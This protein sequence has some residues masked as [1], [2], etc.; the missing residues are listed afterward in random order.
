MGLI[1]FLEAEWDGIEIH[2]IHVELFRIA[3]FGSMSDL[4]KITGCD[5]EYNCTLYWAR[6]QKCLKKKKN[7]E[8]ACSGTPGYAY[9]LPKTELKSK[10]EILPG[11]I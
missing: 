9:Q 4:K 5:I 8:N 10:A 7:S 6:P 11:A 1:R 2:S 3:S